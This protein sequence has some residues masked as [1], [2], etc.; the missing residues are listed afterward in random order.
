M[1]KRLS[2]INQQEFQKSSLGLTSANNQQLHRLPLK[3]SDITKTQSSF[4]DSRT[5]VNPRGILLQEKKQPVVY[6]KRA[7]FLNKDDIKKFQENNSPDDAVKKDVRGE[8]RLNKMQSIESFQSAL[9]RIHVRRPII[10]DDMVPRSG[11]QKTKV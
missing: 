1:S 8:K 2:S 9:D 5:E 6:K 10:F 11:T 3:K 7:T 4:F